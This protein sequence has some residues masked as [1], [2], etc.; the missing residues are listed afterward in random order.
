MAP[1]KG[2]TK[3]PNKTETIVISIVGIA[4]FYAWFVDPGS[5]LVRSSEKVGS[6]NT[7]STLVS[8]KKNE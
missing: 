6:S 2:G 1:T 4:G 7:S 3:L 5:W 8:D